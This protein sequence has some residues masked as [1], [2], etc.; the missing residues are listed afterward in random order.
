MAHV[1]LLIRDEQRTSPESVNLSQKQLTFLPAQV[2]ELTHIERL[3]LSGNLLQSL[4]R[5]LVAL[6]A[7]RYLNIRANAFREIP[8]VVTV[9]LEV[10]LRS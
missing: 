10:M 9:F 7:L 1:S 4:P 3:G 2:L 6:R 8:E 5:E